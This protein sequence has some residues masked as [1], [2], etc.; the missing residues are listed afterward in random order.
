MTAPAMR[1]FSASSFRYLAFISLWILVWWSATLM[2]YQPFVSLWYPPAGLSL[3][4]FIL[5]GTRAF[6]LVLM[7]SLIVGIWM[8]VQMDSSLALGQQAYNSL[9]LAAAHSV[10]Y[11]IGGLYFRQTIGKWDI[12]QLPQRILYFLL[13]TM[14]TTLLAA[15]LGVSAFIFIG[16]MT[17]QQASD[18]WL[19]WW[20]GDLAG[21]I[22]LTPFFILL[23]SQL[24]K[25][26]ISWLRPESLSSVTTRRIN[27][28]WS[29]KITLILALV[30]LVFV[31]DHSFSHP[32]VA[33][34]IFF[35]S[36]P[37]MWI[38]FT[39]R[40]E[41]TVLSLAY[42]SVAI[43]LWFGFY[44]V[45]EHALT[46]QFAIC[47]VAANAYFGLAV[48]SLLSLN[49]KLHH[50]TQIDALTH[51]A[52]RSHFIEVAEAKLRGQRSSDSPLALIVFDLDQFKE[53]N[54]THGHLIGDQALIMAAQSVRTHI[55]HCDLIGRFG[56]DEFLILLPEQ[57]IQQAVETAERL[58]QALPA[59]P[60]PDGFVQIKASFGIVEIHPNETINA[61]L[62]RADQALLKA[63]R[64][65]RDQV[66]SS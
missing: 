40:M 11:G 65:G 57:S 4:A 25:Y 1:Q 8:Y 16:D 52:S 46:Y 29:H 55:R 63:K 2:E 50:Q 26:D 35:I 41:L 38:V 39:E 6:L 10:S 43:A 20:V 19:S 24:W 60:T 13:I 15:W 34:F 14:I 45:N 9:I 44:G 56:G 42:I 18:S 49:K 62:Q 3:A 36:I 7:A 30:G 32:A 31:A 5:M 21:A 48:P 17:W 28:F 47:V 51:V 66:V 37:Q 59:I 33:Y 23:L 58:R 27:S 64:K 22:V 61:A 53:I 54:D 12:Q